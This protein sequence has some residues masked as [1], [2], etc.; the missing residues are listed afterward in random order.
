MSAECLLESVLEKGFVV[1]EGEKFSVSVSE[2]VHPDFMPDPD[3]GCLLKWL[4]EKKRF[5][6][7]VMRCPECNKSITIGKIVGATKE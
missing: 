1:V 6:A 5:S 4:I 3:A 2:K 7:A